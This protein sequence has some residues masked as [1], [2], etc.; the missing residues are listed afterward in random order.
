MFHFHLYKEMGIKTTPI[1]LSM[2]VPLLYDP[3]PRNTDRSSLFFNKFKISLIV[4]VFAEPF[5]PIKPIIQPWG[6]E[7][8][9]FCSANPKKI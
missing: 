8:L 9:M 1:S 4:V 3:V 6:M 7:K 2:T 5:G